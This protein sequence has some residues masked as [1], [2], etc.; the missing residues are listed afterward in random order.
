MKKQTQIPNPDVVQTLD[1][2]FGTVNLL[3]RTLYLVGDIDNEA[4]PRVLASIDLLGSKPFDVR[5]CSNGGNHESGLAIADAISRHG[6]VTVTATGACASAAMLILVAAATRL[7]TANTRFMTHPPSV[8]LPS[9]QGFDPS[10]LGVMTKEL[11][12]ALTQ[13][14][15]F[16][17]ARS[18]LPRSKVMRM[19]KKETYF[20]AA[21][22]LEW[23]FVDG[24]EGDEL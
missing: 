22:A 1:V 3:T 4:L 7:S 13:Y 18:R 24:V 17:T 16:L 9:E 6:K 11:G 10:D 23:G 8:E 14:V 2:G 19:C 20:S 12:W 15:E 21:Q 5:L